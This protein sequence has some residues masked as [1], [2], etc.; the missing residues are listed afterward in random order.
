MY[1]LCV[2]FILDFIVLGPSGLYVGFDPCVRF[3]IEHL[4]K[5]KNNLLPTDHENQ[6]GLILPSHL[7]RLQA[8]EVIGLTN[9][10]STCYNSSYIIHRIIPITVSINC[11]IKS[12]IHYTTE[13]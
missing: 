6:F 5:N 9:C 2:Q 10:V 12:S 11:N 4:Y 7:S 13:E 8:V 3:L 1:F